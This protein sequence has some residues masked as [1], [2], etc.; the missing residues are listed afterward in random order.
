MASSSAKIPPLS[1]SLDA[2]SCT[3]TGGDGSTGGKLN[4][5]ASDKFDVTKVFNIREIVTVPSIAWPTIIVWL[6]AILIQTVATYVYC[7]YDNILQPWQ[8]V[9]INAYASFLVFTPMHDGCHGSIA[10]VSSGYRWLNDF[11]GYTSAALYPAPYA[12]KVLLS[13]RLYLR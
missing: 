10:T 2:G 7:S 12:G 5:A 4:K 6:A 3:G 9:A 1:S 13:K 8:V 11:V